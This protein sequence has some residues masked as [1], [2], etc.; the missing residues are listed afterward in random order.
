[1]EV[2]PVSLF[3]YILLFLLCFVSFLIGWFF[4]QKKKTTKVR[5]IT[6][7]ELP[8]T[9]INTSIQN[10]VRA[11]QTRRRGGGAITEKPTPPENNDKRDSFSEET[12]VPDQKDNLKR[13]N[14]IGP[15]IEKKLNSMGIY[16]FLQIS[17]FKPNDIDRI[18]RDIG[19]FPKKIEKEG[20]IQQ[21]KAFLHA[22]SQ[23]NK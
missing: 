2:L 6:E 13:I 16:T 21:A 15:T 20:W 11:V 23:Q 22:R 1:M 9:D 10:T 17:N 19:Y 8:E 4:G 12:A 7:D 3:E 14:G 18:A 5:T